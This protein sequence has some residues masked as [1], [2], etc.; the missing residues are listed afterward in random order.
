MNKLSNYE[1]YSDAYIE[2]EWIWNHEREDSN[3]RFTILPAVLLVII[4]MI[5]FKI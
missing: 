4:Y 5:I 1:N 2:K 3:Y